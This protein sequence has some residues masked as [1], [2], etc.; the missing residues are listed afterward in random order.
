MNED[1]NEM[2]A[3]APLLEDEVDTD[4]QKV[5][6][7]AESERKTTEESETVMPC[8]AEGYFEVT[9]S[10]EKAMPC[11][12]GAWCSNEEEEELADVVIDGDVYDDY[13]SMPEI[14][15]DVYPDE[16]F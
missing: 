3:Y 1:W 4:Y 12:E 14:P 5:E 11:T 9:E 6:E 7:L 10:A 15:L 2:M 16:E 13:Q 8:D